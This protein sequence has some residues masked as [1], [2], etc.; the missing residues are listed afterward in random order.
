MT[1]EARYAPTEAAKWRA[2]NSLTPDARPV[3]RTLI[4]QKEMMRH[5]PLPP[6]EWLS[7]IQINDSGVFSTARHETL[8]GIV[9][10]N[11]G[12]AN[13]ILEV[14]T[15]P[16]RK[17]GSKG[18]TLFSVAPDD[19]TA[20]AATFNN[21]GGN[22]GDLLNLAYRALQRGHSIEATINNA[23]D[24]ARNALTNYT[25]EEIDLIAAGLASKRKVSGVDFV[26]LIYEARWEKKWKQLFGTLPKPNRIVEKMKDF[27]KHRHTIDEDNEELVIPKRGTCLVV[28]TKDRDLTSY[29]H[30][31][32][33]KAI[34][35]VNV[36]PHCQAI[37]PSGHACPNRKQETGLTKKH[38]LKM[39][40]Q[41]IFAKIEAK[42]PRRRIIYQ[43]PTSQMKP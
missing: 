4:A 26:N 28:S 22:G 20:A 39:N 5:K 34:E 30:Y 31:K 38:S 25:S 3:D 41:E 6:T 40:V 18:H 37:V 16:D 35:G 32:D 13:H 12:L 23:L 11:N 7:S 43:Y 19:A 9:A 24:S 27:T 36:C 2:P 29:T 1:A 10:F 17:K 42:F 33:G 21:D 15:R 8:H 14:S